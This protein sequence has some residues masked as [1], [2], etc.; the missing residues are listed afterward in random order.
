MYCNFNITSSTARGRRGRDHVSWISIYLCNQCLSPI[1]FWVRIPL[2]Q[3]VLDDTTLC[4]KVCEW[5][6]KS[7]WFSP[8]SLVS[9]T[10][11]TDHHDIA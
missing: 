5:L 2:R 8:G 1:T 3:G 4:D 10:N 11:K 7:Q 6:V 9:S